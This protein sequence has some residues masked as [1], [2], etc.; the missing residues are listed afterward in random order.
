MSMFGDLKVLFHLLLHPI[1]GKTHQQ[2]LESFY[3]AQAEEYD[4]FRKNLLHGR[5]EL[6]ASLPTPEDGVWVEIGGGTGSNLEY[7]GDRIKK[8]RKVHIVD[9][10]SSLLGIA[11]KR[12]DRLGWTNV[13]LHEADATTVTLPEL[14]DVVTF[15]Y[16]LT[17]IPDWFAALENAR[18]LLKPGGTIGIVDFFVARKYPAEG[19]VKHGWWTRTFWPTWFA[20]DNV[21]LSPDHIPYLTRHFTPVE[22]CESRARIRYFPLMT[23]PYYRFVGRKPDSP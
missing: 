7:L 1:R 16:S 21:F 4:R 2:R 3:A 19:R 18:R 22:L 12:I 13:E 9:L 15:S 8:I 5:E 6:Y 17:M 20:S 14:A 11:R 10:S 23:T